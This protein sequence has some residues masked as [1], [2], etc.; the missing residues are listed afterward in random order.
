[1]EQFLFSSGKEKQN[2]SIN[3]TRN[4]TMVNKVFRL[5]VDKQIIFVLLLLIVFRLSIIL[6]FIVKQF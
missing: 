1:M 2:E 4:L 6:K 3:Q 5:P